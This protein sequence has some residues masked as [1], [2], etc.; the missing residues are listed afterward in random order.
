MDNHE[1]VEGLKGGS[2]WPETT[3]KL[4]A[5]SGKRSRLHSECFEEKG[6]GAKSD[7]NVRCSTDFCDESILLVP[8]KRQQNGQQVNEQQYSS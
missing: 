5:V 8:G 6:N 1:M 4:M 7:G 3:V 2:L